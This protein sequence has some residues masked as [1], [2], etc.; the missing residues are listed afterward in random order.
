ML[1]NGGLRHSNCLPLSLGSGALAIT[2]CFEDGSNFNH[3]GT[4]T[5]QLSHQCSLVVLTRIHEIVGTV[6]L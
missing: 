6:N 4:H 1:K 3:S 2:L 5:G